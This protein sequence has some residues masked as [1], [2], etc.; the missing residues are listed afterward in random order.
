VFLQHSGGDTGKSG[1]VDHPK[2]SLADD[3]GTKVA[4]HPKGTFSL[5]IPVV[6]IEDILYGQLTINDY[7]IALPVPPKCGLRLRDLITCC[8]VSLIDIILHYRYNNT[9]ERMHD[10]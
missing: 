9:Y 4:I 8:M 3:L 2:T 10:S 1:D 6:T 7:E 5:D